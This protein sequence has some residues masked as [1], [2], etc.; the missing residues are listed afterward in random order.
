VTQ[1]RHQPSVL[2]EVL[3]LHRDTDLG[4]I[5]DRV[6]AE[7]LTEVLGPKPAGFAAERGVKDEE[8]IA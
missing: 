8:R 6:Q 4:T 3:D 7:V 2:A 5:A 1:C